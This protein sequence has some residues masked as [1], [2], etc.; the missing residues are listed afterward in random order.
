LEERDASHDFTK[1]IAAQP[2]PST[3]TRCLPLDGGAK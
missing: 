2:E 3:T 1:L